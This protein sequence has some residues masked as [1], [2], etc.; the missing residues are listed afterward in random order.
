[1]TLA[2]RGANGNISIFAPGV[3]TGTNAWMVSPHFTAT[4][5]I[6]IVAFTK[7]L[8]SRRGYEDEVSA[9]MTFYCTR[10]FSWLPPGARL[11]SLGL[12]ARFWMDP[13][14]NVQDAARA[15]I[16]ETIKAMNAEEIVDMVKF[17]NHIRTF[18]NQVVLRK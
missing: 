5:L 7:A 15:L 3:L 9:V 18:R 1:M 12:L 4:R 6:S 14:E 16:T 2:T 10:I 13:H 11:P 17:W 8:L